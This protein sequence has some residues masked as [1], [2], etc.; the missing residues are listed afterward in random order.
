MRIAFISV[1]DRM[2]GSEA[3]LLET[4]RGLRRTRPEW[5]LHLISPGD[6]AL[7]RAARAAGAATVALP[8]PP[9]IARFGETAAFGG[10]RAV[11]PLRLVPAV[12]AV[13]A[14]QKALNG[15]LD[16]IAPAVV[17]TNGFKAHVFAARRRAAA[18]LVW[19]LHE[20]VTPRRLTRRL[21]R[22]YAARCDAIVAN[23]RSVGADAEAVFA[24]RAAQVIPNA[25]DLDVFSP[26]GEQTDLDALSGLAPAPPGTIRVGLVAAFA[27][28]KGHAVFLEALARLPREL[29]L[30]GYVVG[31]PVYDTAGSQYSTAELATLARVRGLD[32]RLGL[33]GFVA[34]PAGALRALDIVV[35]AS[36]DPEPFG[37]VVAE[38][39]ACGRAV[40][41]SGTGGSAE[42][43]R[44]G[45][46][47]IVHRAG[48]AGDL[49]C[50]IARL[51]GEHMLRRRIG[52]RARATAQA[53]FDS[54]RL[55]EQF[56][57]VYEDAARRRGTR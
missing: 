55:S 50:G 19:H 8:M 28:W 45:V 4:V 34:A 14:Y 29:Q 9:A 11:L 18:A 47:A 43:V 54:R 33:T 56:A 26:D 5:E 15:A 22:H 20:Y 44:D 17:H 3:V 42:L 25:V 21:L 1:S 57:T 38:A 48:D 36:T 30:R 31:G 27:R 10:T 39:M 46:D 23:S 13:P 16:R 37:L 32:G 35:H 41:T 12:A 53:R 51:A 40:V 24:G 52:E 7:P 2:G 49:A 6:G